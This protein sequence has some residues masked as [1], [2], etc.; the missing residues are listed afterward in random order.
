MRLNLFYPLAIAGLLFSASCDRSEASYTTPVCKYPT[1]QE[2]RV[3]SVV[4][5]DARWSYNG[6]DLPQ[7]WFGFQFVGAPFTDLCTKDTNSAMA[8]IRGGFKEVRVFMKFTTKDSVEIPL[9]KVAE[10]TPDQYTWS[11]SVTGIDLSKYYS[12]YSGK[13]WPV[14]YVKVPW[15]LTY[16]DGAEGYEELKKYFKY[17]EIKPTGKTY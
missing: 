12:S 1:T 3:T 10:G 5:R 7:D 6:Y 4:D 11:G 8:T 9:N 13:M 2:L 15:Y 16:A 14:V 17:M